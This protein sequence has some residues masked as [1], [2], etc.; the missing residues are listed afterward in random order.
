MVQKLPLPV[1]FYDPE[2]WRDLYEDEPAG[3]CDNCEVNRSPFGCLSYP[4]DWERWGPCP[5]YEPR[6]EW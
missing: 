4:W 5:R 2:N 1:D 3:S 6:E